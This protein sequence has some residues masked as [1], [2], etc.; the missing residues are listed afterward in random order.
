VGGLQIRNHTVFADYDKLYQNIFAD[1][2]V[3]GPGPGLVELDGYQSIAGRQN[4]VN[5]TDF[6]YSFTQGLHLRH[7]LVGGLEFG[8]QDN[9]EFRNLPVFGAPGSGIFTL[10]VPAL[11]PTVFTP[12]MYS[13]PNRRRFTDL[14][15]TSAFIQDQFEITQYFELIGGI[16]F[17][18]FDVNFED[19]LNGF[20]TSRVD[21]V[22]SPRAG[23]VLRPW[24]R[25]TSMRATP[26]RFCRPTAIIS[27]S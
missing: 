5:Q 6:S 22:W 13:R 3:N 10:N 4:F 8:V 20:Q 26:S 16:R 12:T 21:D 27:A 11:D 17:D 7:T 15:T 23:G 1:S 18:R 25:S 14:D 24:E 2:S 19:R 9:D